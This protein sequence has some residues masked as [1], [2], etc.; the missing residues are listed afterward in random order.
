M[1]T[2]DFLC[3]SSAT[4]KYYVEKFVPLLKPVLHWNINLTIY[5]LICFSYKHL[6]RQYHGIYHTFNRKTQL[7]FNRKNET[8]LVSVTVTCASL[9]QHINYHVFLFSVIVNN[10]KVSCIYKARCS[11]AMGRSFSLFYQHQPLALVAVWNLLWW[12]GSNSNQ[13][14]EALW[15]CF[16]F[17]YL[18]SLGE[19]IFVLFKNS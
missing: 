7:S 5:G 14:D 13:T 8:S 9:S 1:L 12:V 6:R 2:L 19:I 3:F 17:S 15:I 11:Y 10:L 4:I 18:L 16:S